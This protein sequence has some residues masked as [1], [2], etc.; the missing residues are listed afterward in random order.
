MFHVWTGYGRDALGET[1]V[2]AYSY[3]Q[4]SGLGHPVHRLIMGCAGSSKRLWAPKGAPV[5]ARS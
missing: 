1:S 4:T 2:L 5:I 3:Q